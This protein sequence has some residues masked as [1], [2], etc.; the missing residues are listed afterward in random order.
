M[1]FHIHLLTWSFKLIP[2]MTGL[3]FHKERTPCSVTGSSINDKVF[4]D[5]KKN[6]QNIHNLGVIH[7]PLKQTKSNVH[8]RMSKNLSLDM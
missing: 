8:G 4:I 3:I 1:Y 2:E 6:L 7:I 5:N